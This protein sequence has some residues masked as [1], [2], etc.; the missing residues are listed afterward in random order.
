MSAGIY[1]I[2]N[3]ING[4]IYIGGAT[5]LASRWKVHKSLLNNGKHSNIHLQRAWNKENFVFSVLEECDKH[6]LTEREQ[7]Y[8]DTLKPFGEIGYNILPLA[9]RWLGNT[10][11]LGKKLTQEQKLKISLGGIGKQPK[12]KKRGLERKPLSFETKSRMSLAKK[13]FWANDFQ[14]KISREKLVLRNKGLI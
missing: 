14:S 12:V 1:Q 13:K 9:R 11:R 10:A 6:F 8:L 3:L 4:K 5:N 7:F 2:K